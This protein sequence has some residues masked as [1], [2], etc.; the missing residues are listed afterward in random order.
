MN[1][2]LRL[3]TSEQRP[4]AMRRLHNGAGNVRQNY[5]RYLA[6]AREATTNGDAIEAEN[7]YQHAEHYF[8]VM[9]GTGD[10]RRN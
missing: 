7:F 8:R 6:L 2:N 9:R 1:Q 3:R 10:E 5:E 4:V